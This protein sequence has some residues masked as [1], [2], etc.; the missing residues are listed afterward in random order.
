MLSALTFGLCDEPPPPAGVG[1]KGYTM[2][3]MVAT[4]PTSEAND[5][6]SDE[7]EVEE[8]TATEADPLD[9]LSLI[10]I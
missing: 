6:D 8:E 4:M 1:G 7:L 2:M 5:D 10:H 3:P 9:D